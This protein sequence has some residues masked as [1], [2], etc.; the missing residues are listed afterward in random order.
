MILFYTRENESGGGFLNLFLFF[1]LYFLYIEFN[2]KICTFYVY[3][4]RLLCNSSLLRDK[5]MC[6]LNVFVC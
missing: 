4:R 2:F 3:N 1:K 6:K 5:K